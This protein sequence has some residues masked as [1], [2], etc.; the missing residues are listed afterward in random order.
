VCFVFGTEEGQRAAAEMD[1]TIGDLPGLEGIRINQTALKEAMG[2][3]RRSGTESGTGG[4][5]A[6]PLAAFRT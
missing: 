5:M 6:T 2:R 4:H 1:R 3:M